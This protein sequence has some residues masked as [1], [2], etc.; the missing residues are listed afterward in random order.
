MSRAAALAR[1]LA[2]VEEK[3]NGRHLRHP[4]RLTDGR[5]VRLSTF[6][7]LGTLMDGLALEYAERHGHAPPEYDGAPEPPPEHETTPEPPPVARDMALLPPDESMMGRSM[8]AVAAEWCQAYDEGRLV[9]LHEREG[10]A[11]P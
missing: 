10:D 3:R 7:M 1:R 5:T 8:R 4:Y 11:S 6:D 2:A 9:A